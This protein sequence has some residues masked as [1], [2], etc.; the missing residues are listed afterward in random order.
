MN[1][2][3]VEG[4][5]KNGL[6]CWIVLRWC[7]DFKFYIVWSVFYV[8]KPINNLWE[9]IWMLG[10]Q[11]SSFGVKNG[12]KPVRTGGDLLEAR[13][14]RVLS[15]RN[16]LMAKN[17]LTASYSVTAFLVSRSCVL[18]THF[19]FELAFGVNMKVLDNC[20]TFPVALV[21]LENE[22]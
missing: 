13:L 20:V 6:I 19:C 10:D 17:S 16:S 11:N 3:V 8:H 22:F 2:V 5:C 4:L 15:G 12:E 9:Q 18:F 7:F 21:W 14:W 1:W